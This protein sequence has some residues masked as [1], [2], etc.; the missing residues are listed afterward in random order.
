M[1]LKELLLNETTKTRTENNALAYSTTKSAVLD[2][3]GIGGAGRNLEEPLVYQKISQALAEDKELAIRCLLF[4]GD[5]RGGQGERRLFRIGLQV[6]ADVLPKPI[7]ERVLDNVPHFTRWDYLLDFLT[8]KTYD[9]YVLEMFKQEWLKDVPSLLYKWLPKPHTHGKKK[10]EAKIIYTYLGIDEKEYRQKLSRMRTLINLVEKDMSNREWGKIDYSHVPS[11]ASLI[12]KGAFAKHD[13]QRYADFIESV[14]KGE[15]KINASTL[16]PHEIAFQA[17]SSK[18]ETLE[19]LWKSL[20]NYVKDEGKIILPM[21]DVSRSMYQNISPSSSV[22]AIHVSIGLGLYLA[23]RLTGLF[24]DTYLSFSERPVL[25]KAHGSSLYQKLVNVSHEH[26][27]YNTNII[28]VFDVI[29]KMAVGNRLKQNEIPN[30]IVVFSDMEFDEATGDRNRTPF[31]FIKKNYNDNGY[32]LP[33]VVFWNLNARNVQFPVRQD[34]RG[35]ILVS[36]YSPSTLQYVL[37][38]ELKTPYEL[39]VEVLQNA[40][41]SIFE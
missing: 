28:S 17:F 32:E 40:R 41:Y 16:Y 1:D 21:V 14:N 20:P 19:A 26:M 33:Q 31:D 27:G 9:K 11:K 29:L 35:V 5:I 6:I 4:L 15:A 8:H 12:Y 36:G 38:G 37:G 34:Q 22:Q 7:M 10:P 30:T 24:K 3:F 13:E 23:E 18:N 39:M 25:V 2:L